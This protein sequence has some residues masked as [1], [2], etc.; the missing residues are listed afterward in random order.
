LD[1]ERFSQP[2]FIDRYGLVSGSA[3]LPDGT[4]NAVLWLNGQMKDI[5]TPGLGGPNSIAFVDNESSRAVG[6]AE[7]HLRFQW[8]DF[9]GFGTPYLF[10][11]PVAGGNDSVSDNSVATTAWLRRISNRGE[12]AGFA[13]NSTPDPGCQLRKFLHFSLSSGKKD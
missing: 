8:E 3:S 12:V 6:E 11:F 10:T 9:C 5:G 1:G 2:F 7:L 4:Q 13:E